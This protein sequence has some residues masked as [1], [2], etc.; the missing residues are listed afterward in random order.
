MTSLTTICAI[1]LNF[2]QGEGAKNGKK[3]LQK[4]CPTS[5]Y[6]TLDL[7]VIT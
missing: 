3:T 4:T 5:K 7:A 2:H 1:L 6:L